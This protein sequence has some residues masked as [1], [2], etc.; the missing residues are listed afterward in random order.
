MDCVYPVGC[1]EATSKTFVR[2]DFTPVTNTCT[3]MLR[4][5]EM[6]AVG[7]VTREKCAP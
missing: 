6:T 5:I 3:G 2:M 7:I 1:A 4:G